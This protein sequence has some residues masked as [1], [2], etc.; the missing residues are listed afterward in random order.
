MTTSNYT[1]LGSLT[2]VALCSLSA[3]HAD[4]LHLAHDDTLT[5]TIT[6]IDNQSVTLTSTLAQAPLKIKA[7]KIKKITFDTQETIDSHHA[8]QVSLVNGDILPCQVISMDSDSLLVSTWYAGKLQIP[9]GSIQ[10][11]QFGIVKNKLIYQGT[12]KPSEW[13]S[14]IGKWSR[15]ETKGYAIQGPGTLARK[16]AP[17]ENLHINFDLAWE[18]SPNFIFRFFADTEQARSKQNAYEFAFNSRGIKLQ[19]VLKENAPAPL[20]SINLKPHEVEDQKINVDILVNREL[21]KITLHL[22][23]VMAGTWVDSAGTTKGNY[24]ILC[25]TSNEKT[26]TYVN[27]LVV[28]DWLNGSQPRYLETLSQGKDDILIDNEGDIISGHLVSISTKKTT[29]RIIKLQPHHTEKP[30]EVPEPRVS[31]LIFAKSENAVSQVLQHYTAQ[32]LGGGHIQLESPQLED[33]TITLHHSILGTFSIDTGAISNI[34]YQTPA[35]E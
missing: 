18:A 4:V 35:P 3:T 6:G 8:E 22:D 17:A 26:N 30:I 29:P 9:R 16:L 25:N 10:S 15:L 24:M 28:H 27:N 5:G 20:T 12:D 1:L 21:G 11:L 13:K 19:R 7:D 32:L 23:G 2:A 33:K 31:S 14:N 34:T